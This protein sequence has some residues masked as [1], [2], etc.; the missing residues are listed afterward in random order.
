[1]TARRPIVRF[2]G[3]L[4]RSPANET[5]TGALPCVTFAPTVKRP[6][7][8][9]LVRPIRR[10]DFPSLRSR[11]TERPAT[12][13]V[14]VPRAHA[15]LLRL[16]ARFVARKPRRPATTT[17]RSRLDGGVTVPAVSRDAGFGA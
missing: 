6:L 16:T 17:P 5:R 10:Q 8:S 3:A 15:R 13:G 7:P 12:A 2:A 9:V 11:T 1:M 14:R 4:R